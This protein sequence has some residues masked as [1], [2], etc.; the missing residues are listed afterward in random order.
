MVEILGPRLLL[1]RIKDGT[2]VCRHLD[3]VQCCAEASPGHDNDQSSNIECQL[4]EGT[5][6]ES[7]PIEREDTPAESVQQETEVTQDVSVESP[8]LP[9]TPASTPGSDP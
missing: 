1:V 7:E 9:S 2:L 3:Q 8:Q 4:M 6:E 5:S